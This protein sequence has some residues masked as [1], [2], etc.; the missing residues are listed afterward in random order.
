MQK[1]ILT[2]HYD[3]KG[4][5]NRFSKLGKVTKCREAGNRACRDDFDKPKRSRYYAEQV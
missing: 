5:T 2:K 4:M 3:N 1:V